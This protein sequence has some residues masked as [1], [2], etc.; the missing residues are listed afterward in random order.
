MSQ[1]ESAA[2][3]R[4]KVCGVMRAE[5]AVLAAEL[6]ASAIGLLFWPRSPRAVTVAQ[7]RE[8]ARVLPPFVQLVGVFV[9]QPV[10]QVRRCAEDAR[11]A[12][13]QLHGEEDLEM[14]AALAGWP[15]LKSVTANEA[16]VD[17]DLARVPSRVTVLIDAHDPIRRGGTGR[18]VPWEVAAAV[19][20][21][22]RLV[23]SGGLTAENV[24][25]AI[26]CV[27]PWAVDVASGVEE[28]PGIKSA[29]RLRAFFA[30]VHGCAPKGVRA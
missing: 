7:A 9:N 14:F 22:R 28:R 11:L 24:A 21:R 20:V 25:D 1:P 17:P 13:I 15:L 5:D 12:A 27:R 6:G 8:V 30:A 10:E 4:V 23:L 19:A 2:A 16:V 29:A 18:T 26:G 3:V